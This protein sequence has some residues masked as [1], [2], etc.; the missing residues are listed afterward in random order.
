M[1]LA[2]ALA[3]VVGLVVGG[4]VVG[5]GVMWLCRRP[6]ETSVEYRGRVFG[7]FDRGRGV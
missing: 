6:L 5:R 3:E 7:W 2:A 4:L 1:T